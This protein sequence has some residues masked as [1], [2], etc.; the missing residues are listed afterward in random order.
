MLHL[1]LKVLPGCWEPLDRG[2]S[3]SWAE[4]A[5]RGPTGQVGRCDQEQRHPG[6]QPSPTTPSLLPTRPPWPPATAARAM[7]PH[8]QPPSS[9]SLQP[10]RHRSPL[11][12]PPREQPLRPPSKQGVSVSPPRR[13]FLPISAV[14][15]RQHLRPLPPVLPVTP[16]LGCQG[17]HPL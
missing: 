2:E 9:R 1:A 17:C 3:V 4:R 10:G 6:P 8:L 12:P 16:H 15:P 11:C 7:S 14:R 13:P 5:C